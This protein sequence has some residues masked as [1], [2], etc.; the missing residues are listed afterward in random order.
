MDELT[1]RDYLKVIFRQK[2]VIIT[3]IITV[4]VVVGL[5]LWI[6]TPTYEATVK[7]LVTAQKGVENPYY[8]PLI[9]M[10]NIQVA[11]TQS[12]IVKSN[13]VMERTLK[14]IG[15]KPETLLF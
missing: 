1:L 11:L 9:E 2:W 6:K 8:S 13:P 14:A 12:E 7:M 3:T 15:L 4:T 10:Q 5:G